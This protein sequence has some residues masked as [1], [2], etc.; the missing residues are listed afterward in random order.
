MSKRA[1]C[2]D[3]EFI[4][5]RCLCSTLKSIDNKTHIIIL[6]HPS[7]S[8]HAL[9]TVALMKKSYLKITVFVGEN[10]SEHPEL[11]SIIEANQESIG[12]IFPSQT[13]ID[14]NK[15]EGRK[16]THLLFIDGTWKKAQKIHLL[17]KNLH[18]LNTYSLYPK[19]AGQYKIRSS[20]FE[21]S[22]STLEASICSLEIIEN[23][24]N[25]KSLEDSFLKMI[26]FQIDKMGEELFKKNYP[27]KS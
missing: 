11:N 27:K 3:C 1:L 5:A 8:R 20:H 18:T 24:L 7:E 4:L 9:N 22:L 21:Q 2:P 15:S 25:T 6:Q 12:L 13:S 17:S 26:E 19:K 23:D 10:F 14:L 16:I